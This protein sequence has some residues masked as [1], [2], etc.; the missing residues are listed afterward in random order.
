MLMKNR[1]NIDVDELATA[2]L[3]NCRQ[4]AQIAPLPIARAAES[5]S[6]STIPTSFPTKLL[7][8]SS[9]WTYM[10]HSQMLGKFEYTLPAKF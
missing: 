8:S 10:S 3:M 2:T 6:Y 1:P 9:Y 7:L 4:V 5:H